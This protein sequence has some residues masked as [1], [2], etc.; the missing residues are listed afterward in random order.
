MNLRTG[1]A[2]LAAVMLGGCAWI[3]PALS[4]DSRV[5]AFDTSAIDEDGLVGPPDGKRSVA[6]EYCVPKAPGPLDEVRRIDP[7]A[8]PM[9]GARGRIGCGSTQV[10]V[11]GSTVGPNWRERLDRLAALP[12]VRRIREVHF[13]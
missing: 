1:V 6:Y 13:E 11:L 7:T 9:P 8:E 4:S 2:G 10:L 5:I 12:Y 3:G